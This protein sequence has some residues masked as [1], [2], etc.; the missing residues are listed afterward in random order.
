MKKVLLILTVFVS[1]FAGVSCNQNHEHEDSSSALS[2]TTLSL[3]NGSK[4]IADS[5]TSSNYIDLRTIT[6]MFAVAPNPSL[7]NYQILGSDLG[8]GLNKMISECKMKGADHDML[9]R[10]L[11][12][13]LSQTGDLKNVTDTIEGRKL[14]HS[15]H[16]RID[17]FYTYFKEAE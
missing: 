11:E 8:K 2:D 6:N 14:F 13:I 1:G 10:W 16:Q 9:H 17:A 15:L 12:P 5:I 7:N 3:N 4:W